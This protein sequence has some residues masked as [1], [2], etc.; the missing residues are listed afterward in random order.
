[1]GVI[2]TKTDR[3]CTSY[4]SNLL[5]CP[6]CPL[7]SLIWASRGVYRILHKVLMVFSSLPV[8]MKI[9]EYEVRDY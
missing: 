6:A 1:M 4:F 5:Q 9:A 8:K 7:K 2:E 3:P